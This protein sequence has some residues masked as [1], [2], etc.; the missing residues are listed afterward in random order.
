MRNK[1]I[2]LFLREK[3]FGIRLLAILA[4]MVAIALLHKDTQAAKI[5]LARLKEEKNL[6]EQIPR[7]EERLHILE[8]SRQRKL[9]AQKAQKITIAINGIV[10]QNN[11]PF[12]LIGEDLFG[13]GE[14]IDGYT[15][16]K[17]T[18][19]SVILEDKITKS[20]HTIALSPAE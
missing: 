18:L 3:E 1:F 10:I 6:A 17:V 14:S 12:V 13:E 4:A 9:S 19:D 5:R 8:L 20:H 16:Y 7:L 2:N 11:T 15:I